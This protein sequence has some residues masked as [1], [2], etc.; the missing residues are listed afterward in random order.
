MQYLK[1]MDE[2]NKNDGDSSRC[3]K[4]QVYKYTEA[5]FNGTHK[6]PVFF[7]EAYDKAKYGY[8][9]G[10]T[11]WW[12]ELYKTSFSQIYNANISGGNDRLLLLCHTIAMNNQ[13]GILTAGDDKYFKYNANV[14]ISSN[15]TKWLNVSAKISHTYTSELHPTGGTTAMNPTAY[16]GLS[17][18]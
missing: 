8:C 11:N 10:N 16:S 12:N 2:A 15:I 18:Y 5:Y 6:D 3:F 14:N 9:R 4:D 1:M 17:A 13:K 7:D